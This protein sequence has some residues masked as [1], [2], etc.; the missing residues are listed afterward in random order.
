MSDQTM[1]R[2]ST[3]APALPRALARYA[4]FWIS[5]AVGIALWEI[6]GRYSNPAFLVPFSETL[7]S[8]WSLA[9]TGQLGLQLLDSG[10]LFVTGFGLAVLIG[11]PLGLLLA[12]V[13]SLRVALEPYIMILYA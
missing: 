9:A 2:S 11:I 3:M 13:W 10:L 5:L 6:V 4:P 1:Q 12:R 7:A 8:L